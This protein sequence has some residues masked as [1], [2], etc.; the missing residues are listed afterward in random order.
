MLLN[1]G[2]SGNALLVRVIG[3]KSDSNDTTEVVKDLRPTMCLRSAKAS[4][5][6]AACRSGADEPGEWTSRKC[7]VSETEFR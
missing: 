4:V 6:L 1:E 2:G 7:P 5:S 3:T